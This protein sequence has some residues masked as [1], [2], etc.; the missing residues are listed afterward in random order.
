MFGW[1]KRKPRTPPS[2]EKVVSLAP[3]EVFPWPKRMLLTAVDELMLCLPKALLDPNRPFG[4]FVFASEGM[5]A[6]VNANSRC[7]GA[8]CGDAHCAHLKLTR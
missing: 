3:G 6:R 2:G 7:D 5:Q 1:F 8:G 4:E